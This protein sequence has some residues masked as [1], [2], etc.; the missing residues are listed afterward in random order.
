MNLGVAIL[1]PQCVV[2]CDVH[3]TEEREPQE[4][5]A[6]SRRDQRPT[7]GQRTE[8]KLGPGMKMREGQEQRQSYNCP[9]GLGAE[10]GHSS[11]GGEERAEEW[12]V[13]K[14]SRK[15]LSCL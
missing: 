3:H 10:P 5:P 11:K 15:P 2:V 14:L 1:K 6:L 12:A 7:E 9:A 4:A 13:I 8:T